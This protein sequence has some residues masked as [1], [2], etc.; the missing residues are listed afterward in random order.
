M[1]AKEFV[2]AIRERVIEND[3]SIYR[4]L[5]NATVDS[6]DS[7]WKEIL[8]LY[9]SLST[10]QQES[11]LKFLR[12]IQVNTVSHLFGILDGSTFL[13]ENRESFILKTELDERVINGDLLDLFLELEEAT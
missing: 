6:K 9:S 10:E 11:L 2:T 4:N 3:H 1:K 7:I 8:S 5:L 13:D 12:M